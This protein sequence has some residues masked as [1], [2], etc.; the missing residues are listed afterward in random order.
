VNAVLA[1][2]FEHRAETHP[3]HRDA[4]LRTLEW[5]AGTGDALEAVRRRIAALPRWRLVYDAPATGRLYAERRARF[6]RIVD[7]VV[8]IIRAPAENRVEI[9]V[10]SRARAG[11]GDFGRNA[12]NI[13]ELLGGLVPLDRPLP[14]AFSGELET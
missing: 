3:Q 10:I 14:G 6:G 4:R 5:K 9:D 12:R 1:W 2:L 13:R 11:V 7:E 8:V